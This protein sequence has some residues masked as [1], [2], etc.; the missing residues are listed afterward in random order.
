VPR[1]S[2]VPWYWLVVA[3]S[4]IALLIGGIVLSH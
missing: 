2:G 3:A 4:L 1:R